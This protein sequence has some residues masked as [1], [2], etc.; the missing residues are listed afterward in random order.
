MAAAESARAPSG[1]FNSRRS[2]TIRASTGKAVTDIEIPTNSA[3]ARNRVLG[4][5]SLYSGTATS[6]PA[7]NG[8]SSAVLE[9]ASVILTRPRSWLRSTSRPIRNM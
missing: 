4:A 7:I 9:T 1:R 8:I 3:K 6:S 2:E 5:S